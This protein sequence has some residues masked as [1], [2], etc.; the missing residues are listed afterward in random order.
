MESGLV[1]LRALLAFLHGCV[2]AARADARVVSSA[3]KSAPGRRLGLS[4]I[5]YG[6]KISASESSEPLCIYIYIYIYIHTYIHTYIQI[7]TYISVCTYILFV[8]LVSIAVDWISDVVNLLFC[9]DC[10]VVIEHMYAFVVAVDSP[11]HNY[12]DMSP[13]QG[14]KL[15]AQWTPC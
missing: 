12:T 1:V 8:C 3:S 13:N 14:Q 5:S 15:G 11:Y 10:L 4:A 7:W 2:E 6:T 9:S